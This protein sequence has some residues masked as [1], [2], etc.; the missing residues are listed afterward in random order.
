MEKRNGFFPKGDGVFKG[1]GISAVLNS[2]DGYSSLV[3]LFGS[4]DAIP[5]SV[6][7]Q[8]KAKVKGDE[9][10]HGKERSYKASSQLVRSG[11]DKDKHLP[12][13]LKSSL[14]ISGRGCGSGALS[15]FPQ[16]VGR[17]VLLLYSEPGQVVFDPFAGHN[18]RMSLCVKN[19]RHYI[20]CDLSTEF[21]DFNFRK[22]ER[23]RKEYPQARI[24]LHHTDSRSVPVPDAVG[25][26]TITSPPY[27]DI[28]YYGDEPEQLGKAR[29]YEG[30]LKG[31]RK[32]MRENFRC[33]KA[34][35]YAAWFV[36]DFRKNGRMHFYHIDTIR[37]M[38][39]VG[40]VAHDLIVVDL[41]RGIRDC[42][43]NQIV[44]T[45]VVPKRHEY[46]LIFRK[47]E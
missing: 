13:I 40:F 46:A 36:N 31:L 25:D 12:N 9:D 32:V 41:G 18:S 19:G 39:S 47:P 29:T 38:E 4:V 45:R 21:M 11:K 27:Y 34:G 37:L 42:F 15:I 28:E 8:R 30:F 14:S 35:A 16:D 1:K 2:R 20:G 17:S 7:R 6:M 43:P 5:S 33:L 10:E 22:A 44:K 23:L 3:S 26:V 24:E